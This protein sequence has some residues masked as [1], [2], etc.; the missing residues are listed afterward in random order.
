M[1][2]AYGVHHAL[3]TSLKV[4]QWALIENMLTILDPCEQL[5]RDISAAT[6]TAADV[7]PSIEALKCFLNKTIATDMGVKTSK[8]TLLQAVNQRFDHIHVEPLYYLA[9]ILNPR[10]KDRYFNQGT[11]RQATESCRKR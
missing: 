4:H 1:L 2:A 10:F 5:T 11:K 6:A 7:I 9:T 8:S 3:P